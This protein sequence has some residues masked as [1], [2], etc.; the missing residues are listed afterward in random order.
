[1]PIVRLD[2]SVGMGLKQPMYVLQGT[3]Q[4]SY[5][6]DFISISSVEQSFS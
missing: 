1:M 2:I 3:K 6:I 4:S 5:A